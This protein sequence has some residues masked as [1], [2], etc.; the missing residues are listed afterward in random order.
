[1]SYPEVESAIGIPGIEG[2]SDKTGKVSQ[3]RTDV[4]DHVASAMM[5]HIVL[6]GSQKTSYWWRNP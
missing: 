3:W 1:M 4:V 2:I 5:G 6:Q